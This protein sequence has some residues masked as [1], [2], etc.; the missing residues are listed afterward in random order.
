MERLE[1]IKEDL[2]RG[3]KY[4]YSAMRADIIWL[5]GTLLK[6]NKLVDLSLDVPMDEAAICL[7]SQDLKEERQ[8]NHEA[9]LEIESI[10]AKY[11]TLQKWIREDR[12]LTAEAVTSLADVSP[13]DYK[14]WLE[15]A[16]S[17]L[18]PATITPL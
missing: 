15:G 3:S 2:A 8:R 18:P 14:A 11:L 17:N 7:L 12:G 9:K 16:R 1:L 4:D 5:L 10:Q 13:A 6:T